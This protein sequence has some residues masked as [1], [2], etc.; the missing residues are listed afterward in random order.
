VM[1]LTYAHDAQAVPLADSLIAEL[2]PNG[3]AVAGCWCWYAAGECRIEDDPET[4]RINLERAVHLA[5]V[6]GSVFVEG[7]AGASLASLDVRSGDIEAA[8]AN[9]RWLLPLWLRSG[10]RSPFWTSMRWVVEL[11]ARL[12]ADEA[13]ARLLG[14]VLSPSTGHEV[15]GDDDARLAQ[16]R[17]DLSARLGADRFAELFAAGWQLDDAAA[18]T[19]ATAAFDLHG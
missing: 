5:R 16:L 4:A 3:G 6:G 18:A 10:V 8:I 19:E 15:Y 11:C 1:C 2:V 9:Y 13:A 17:R 7:V 12:G 14:A